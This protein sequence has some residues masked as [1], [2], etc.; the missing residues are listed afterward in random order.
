[1][2]DLTAV[3]ASLNGTAATPVAAADPFTISNNGG[4]R[5]LVINSSGA[6]RTFTLVTTEIIEND[7]PVADRTITIASDETHVWLGPYPT[8]RY[9]DESNE[10]TFE[11]FNSTSGL[12]F[13]AVQ[14]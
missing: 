5:I 2:A 7:L 11:T 8:A 12:T 6:E 3:S 1:M 4:M 13:L 10:I 14:S 9:N